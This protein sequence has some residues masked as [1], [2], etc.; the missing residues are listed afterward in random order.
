MENITSATVLTWLLFWIVFVGAIS[1]VLLQASV[2][3][4]SVE[5]IF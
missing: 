5:N 3:T 1:M 2:E 4:A